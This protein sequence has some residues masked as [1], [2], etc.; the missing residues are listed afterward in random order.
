VKPTYCQNEIVVG[1]LAL[2]FGALNSAGFLSSA[3][4]AVGA[5]G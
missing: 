3:A 1:L 2:T 4:G 5:V